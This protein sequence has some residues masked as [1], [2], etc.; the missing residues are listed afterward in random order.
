AHFPGRH[1]AAA[2]DLKS[3]RNGGQGAN[4][5]Q[6]PSHRPALLRVEAV[7]QQQ[8]KSRTKGCTG[9]RDE[10]ELRQRNMGLS[11]DRPSTN[12]ACTTGSMQVQ[13]ECRSEGPE[14]RC[15]GCSSCAV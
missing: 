12:T 13:H 7:S 4:N 14:I 9:A 15:Q 3:K 2:E 1:P 6:R 5:K 10:R 8:T 11:H